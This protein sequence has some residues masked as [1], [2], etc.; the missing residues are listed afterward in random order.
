MNNDDDDAISIRFI[1]SFKLP[2]SKSFNNNLKEAEKNRGRRKL[3]KISIFID[4]LKL[5]FL[6]WGKIEFEMIGKLLL[7]KL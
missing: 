7:R 4:K 2:V 3:Q 5:R 1:S 6:C